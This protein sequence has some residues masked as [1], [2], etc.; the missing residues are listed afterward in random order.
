MIISG[1]AYIVKHY[2]T[3]Q[4]ATFK[5]QSDIV[6]S[7]TKDTKERTASHLGKFDEILLAVRAEIKFT[8]IEWDNLSVLFP[9]D[10]YRLGQSVF[11]DTDEKTEIYSADGKKYTFHR[12]ALTASPN[13]G[14]GVEKDLLGEAT[15][16]ALVAT[17]K[18]F[19][20]T[21]AIFK[22]ESGTFT[23]PDLDEDKIFSIPFTVV[24]GNITLAA[25]EGVDIELTPKLTERKRDDIGLFNYLFGGL[26]ATAKFTPVDITEAQFNT[27]ANPNGGVARGRS[28]RTLAKDLVIKGSEAGDP[29]LTLTKA[30]C[31][32]TQTLTFGVEAN[33]FG[34]L[35]FRATSTQ[36]S[37]PKFKI[38]A[39][40]A[41]EQTQTQSAKASTGAVSK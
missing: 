33:R 30:V 8:P 25:E 19:S 14:A 22:S 16:T 7:F 2:G 1:P 24:Y 29:L 11:P 4:S 37:T 35:E 34:E 40:E 38:A 31:A 18:N 36:Y 32:G 10:N 28:L 12:T 41:A 20:D 13:I 9:W 26:E 17:G 3:N 39:V 23:P 21:E 6:V 5:S 27:L 15:I